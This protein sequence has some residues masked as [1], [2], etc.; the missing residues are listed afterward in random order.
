VS[1]GRDVAGVA[2]AAM[3]ASVALAVFMAPSDEPRRAGAP[4]CPQHSIG[5][6]LP[7]AEFGDR[8]T[9]QADYIMDGLRPR[10]DF[11][12]LRFTQDQIGLMLERQKAAVLQGRPAI[13]AR[14]NLAG[15]Q[16]DGLDLSGL[17]LHEAELTCAHFAASK[18]DRAYFF[19]AQLDRADFSAVTSATGARFSVMMRNV[20]LFRARL[21]GTALDGA[22]L[23]GASFDRTSLRDASIAGADLTDAAWDPVVI[24]A[25]P[26]LGGLRGLPTLRP[27]VPALPAPLHAEPVLA[28][29]Q[30]LRIA[31]RTAGERTAEDEV[32]RAYEVARTRQLFANAA[33][34]HNNWD[35][36]LGVSRSILWGWLTDYGLAPWRC[37]LGVLIILLLGIPLY[38]A[39]IPL[40]PGTASTRLQTVLWKD[41]PRANGNR[42]ETGPDDVF[43]GVPAGGFWWRL[44]IAICASMIGTV[45]VGVGDANLGEWLARLRSVELDIVPMGWLRVV[46]GIQSLIATLILAI[47]AICMFGHPFE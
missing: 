7:W 30:V 1:I 42:V 43:T 32:A 31:L 27:V 39:E 6:P 34:E 8:L 47:W 17:D 24:P 38:L 21:D 22:D 11:S 29:L 16:F 25:G 2:L 36:L 46:A 13:M 41:T 40:L 23:S 4:E 18:L 3:V 20:N 9:A 44:R 33:R 10:P 28:G 26:A 19:N 35:W 14:A 5:P 45:S 15:S 12:N 37:L